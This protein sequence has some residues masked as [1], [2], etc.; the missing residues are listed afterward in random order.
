MKGL[1]AMEN[2]SV[3]RTRRLPTKAGCIATTF[4]ASWAS[5][6]SLIG[7]LVGT[8]LAAV[9]VDL[10]WPFEPLPEGVLFRTGPTLP[11]FAMGDGACCTPGEVC[12]EGTEQLGNR[13]GTVLVEVTDACNLEYKVCDDGSRGDR[14]PAHAREGA[15][16][17]KE[18]GQ[19]ETDGDRDHVARL[20]PMRGGLELVHVALR[21]ERSAAHPRAADP[22][23]AIIASA[24]PTAARGARLGPIQCTR[25]IPAA[26]SST[27]CT[28]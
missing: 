4:T 10:R 18:H 21:R 5:A 23:T 15:P 20:Q 27:R 9:V 19:P 26:C 7:A 17:G 11:W 12:R 24:D 1:I 6:T 2:M 22:L 14:L 25:P 3:E 13:N 16:R 8:K 28:T